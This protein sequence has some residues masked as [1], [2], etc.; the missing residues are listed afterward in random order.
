MSC[1]SCNAGLV[2]K[3]RWFYWPLMILGC[4]ILSVP[5]AILGAKYGVAG[6]AMGFLIGAFGVGLPFD[7]FLENRFS[8]LRMRQDETSTKPTEGDIQ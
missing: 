6:A 1:P 5:L 8:V 7:R 2:I 4:C 3:H